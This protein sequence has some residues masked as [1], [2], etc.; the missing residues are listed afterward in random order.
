MTNRVSGD[1]DPALTATSRSA[2]LEVVRTLKAYSSGMVL[3]GGWVP[4]LLLD[5]HRRHGEPF[6]HVGSVDIDFILDPDEVRD[7]DYRSIVELLAVQG[8]HEVPGT[9]YRYTRKMR[10]PDG[11]ERDIL[12]DFLAPHSSEKGRRHRLREVQRGLRAHTL[13]ASQL[14]LDHNS[15]KRLSGKMPDG[16]ETEVDIRVLDVVG[17]IGMKA[18]ALDDRVSYKDAYDIVS[19]LDNYG[20]GVREVAG[21]VRPYLSEPLMSEA[22]S[23]VSKKFATD[24]T[25]G[26]VWYALFMQPGDEDARQRHLT[27]AVQVGSEF[28]R[29]VRNA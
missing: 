16:A 9:V 14:A 6:V 17:C 28:V 2:L 19:V 22:L 13:S 15:T 8:W 20:E 3:I 23:I 29:L 24:T 26:S 27:R 1:F 10:G 11:V 12:V 21:L 18:F 7:V 4:Y 25:E 5:E